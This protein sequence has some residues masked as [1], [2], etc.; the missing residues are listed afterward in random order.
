MCVIT[1]NEGKIETNDDLVR[2]EEIEDLITENL[3]DDRMNQVVFNVS[4]LTQPHP[5]F[6]CQ[7]NAEQHRLVSDVW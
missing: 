3:P 5:E 7:T 1:V 4:V 6:S 2:L